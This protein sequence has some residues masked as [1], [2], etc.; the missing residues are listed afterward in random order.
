MAN[1][2]QFERRDTQV[3]GISTDARPTQ[4]AYYMCLGP[5]VHYPIPLL[6]D[7]EPKGRVSRLY[8][9]YD[10]NTGTAKRS[11]IVIDKGGFVVFSRLYT[12]T[13]EAGITGQAFVESDL[14][15]NNILEELD[16]LKNT[17]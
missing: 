15:V 11:V 14:D 13:I 9:V 8:G 2:S 3:L 6:S 16:H 4:T 10:E 5:T 17:V 12:S 1:S 7:F